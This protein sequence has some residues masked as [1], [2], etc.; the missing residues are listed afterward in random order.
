M[1][2]E[3]IK[4]ILYFLFLLSFTMSCEKKQSLQRFYVDHEEKQ[5]FM[6]LDVPISLLDIED[7][8]TEKQKDAY[9]S[10][11]KFNALSY[12]IEDGGEEKYDTYLT[13]IKT[14]FKNLVYEEL[15]RG[16]IEGGK[17]KLMFTGE[18]DALDELIIFAS[19]KEK[20]FA[21]VRVLG[22]DMNA[23]DL[24]ELGASL[25]N[26]NPDN[27]NVNEILNFFK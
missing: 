23:N 1:K 24:I 20:G 27:S 11:D 18:E 26:I 15:M 2:F 3:S 25:E 5:G 14:I 19:S 7:K 6:S 16:T 4:K 21:V 13:E 12:R 10:V 17:F 8:L 22:D 9:E